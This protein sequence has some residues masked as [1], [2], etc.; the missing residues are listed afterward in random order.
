[1]SAARYRAVLTGATGGIG[2]AMALRLGPLCESL[3][4]VAR[5]AAALTA[6]A[7]EIGAT[8]GRARG[9]GRP[10]HAGRAG[11]SAARRH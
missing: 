8:G 5:D 6:L 11:S 7:R 3:L 10:D 2:R 4:L 9:A 1:M